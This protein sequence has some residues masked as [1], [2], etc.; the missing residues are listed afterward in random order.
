MVTEDLWT[1]TGP[2]LRH[3]QCDLMNQ[4]SEVRKKGK[5]KDGIKVLGFKNIQYLNSGS[6]LLDTDNG[7]M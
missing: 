3:N 6:I 1:G 4:M 5:I 2:N 7:Q